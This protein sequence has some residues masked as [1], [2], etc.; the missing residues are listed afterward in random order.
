VIILSNKPKDLNAKKALE[1]LKMEIAN[2]FDANLTSEEASD[3]VTTRDLVK[4]AER[5]INDKNTFNPS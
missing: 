3:G 5:K 1:K 4:R 2:E